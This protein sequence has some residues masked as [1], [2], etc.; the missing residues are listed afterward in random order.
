[1]QPSGM[2]HD[3]LEL[4]APENAGCEVTLAQLRRDLA[5]VGN[6]EYFRS[7]RWRCRIFWRR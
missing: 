5:V 2:D 1:M 3:V 7:D 6:D 4:I